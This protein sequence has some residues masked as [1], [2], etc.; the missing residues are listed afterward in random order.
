MPI[1]R[2]I[3]VEGMF[4]LAQESAEEIRKNGKFGK[5][6]T[7]AKFSKK[8]LKFVDYS[9]MPRSSTIPKL[10]IK[11]FK[12]GS[13]K[14]LAEL[15]ENTLFL[16]CMHFQDLYNFDCDRASKCVI[17][18]ATPDGRVIPFCTYN[19]IHRKE[20]ERKFARP[21]QPQALRVVGA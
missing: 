4:E 2:F 8:F 21:L 17:H 5:V 16:G 1:T 14:A 10:L 20:V 9:T 18:Y 6:A 19:T 7:I 13:R 12:D 11:I 3:N 15:F